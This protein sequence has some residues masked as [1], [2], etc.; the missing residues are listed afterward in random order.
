VPPNNASWSLTMTTT[1]NKFVN[2]SIDRYSV[3]RFSGLVPNANGSIT[4]YI[5]SMPPA[6]NESNWLPAPTGDFKLW[7][8]VFEPGN[9]IL[10]GSYIVPSVTEVG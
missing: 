9:A 10:N 8:R 2:N 7:L 1:Q 3:G 6:G 5:Q 4:I